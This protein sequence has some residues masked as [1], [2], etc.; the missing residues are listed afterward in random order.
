M[1]QLAFPWL[2]TKDR[3]R[4]NALRNII[5]AVTDEF[6]QKGSVATGIVRFT[7]EQL[8][9]I[10]LRQ[11]APFEIISADQMSKLSPYPFQIHDFVS[12]PDRPDVFESAATLFQVIDAPTLAAPLKDAEVIG[13]DESKVD[14]PFPHSS[15]AFL[16][17]VAFRMYTGPD[18]TPDESV[19]PIVSKVRMQPQDDARFDLENQLLGYIRNNFVAYITSLSSLAVGRRPFVV[20]HGPLLRAIGSFSEISFPYEVARD[21]FHMNL[22][23]AGE[24]E[25]PDN[26]SHSIYKGDKFTEQNMSFIPEEAINGD[27]NLERFNNFCLNYCQ[28]RCAE[29]RAFKNM[30]KAVPPSQKKVTKKMMREREYPGFCLY[31][32]MLRS[33]FDL[34]RLSGTTIASVVET[35]S[36][37]TEM[38][39]I[40][41]P[42]LLSLPKVYQ[43]IQ[44]SAL[45]PVLQTL[46]ISN[47]KSPQQSRE[48]Y[49]QVRDMIEKLHL[50]DANIFSYVLT[51]GQFTAPVQIY[52]YQT[53]NTFGKAL[54]Y[55]SLGIL[56]DFEVILDTLFPSRP[57]QLPKVAEEHPGYVA[58]MSYLRTTPLREP[59]RVE[60]FH[61]PHL[62]DPRKVLG[63]LYLLSIPYQEYGMPIILY[64]VD[65]LARTPTQIA[66]TIIE[67]AYLEMIFENH[68]SDPVSVQTVLG[69]FARGYLQRE[70]LR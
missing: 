6:R 48:F 38:A 55:D 49:R 66:R 41:L 30:Q 7:T 57:Y 62:A 59:V 23:E 69:H 64:Y 12:T 31:F 9:G 60:Y 13:I 44:Q 3:G 14:I 65:K 61:L 33:L 53:K 1:T 67:R 18:G 42:S 27:K 56:N 26:Y 2:Y 20:L 34:A 68:L 37:S 39:R 40:V 24:Y 51:E 15:L 35:T 4:L 36:A 11:K 50:V 63:P 16:K 25:L 29:C 28:R 70:G 8:P 47:L 19:G 52:R 10:I 21:L 5:S 43:E 22:G 45:M 58:L 17:S 54:G 46:G 32:W